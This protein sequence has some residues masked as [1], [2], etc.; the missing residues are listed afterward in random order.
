MTLGSLLTNLKGR[1]GLQNDST[2]DTLLRSWINDGQ[3]NITTRFLWPFLN[4]SETVTTSDGTDAYQLTADCLVYDVRDTTNVFTL[5]FLPDIE[6]DR[7]YVQQ[8]QTGVPRF[9]RLFGQTKVS[10]STA[11][12]PNL[13]LYPI[14]GGTYS[15]TVKS[16]K[17]LADMTDS[18]QI[19]EVP[20]AYHELMIHYAANIY[21]SSRGDNRAVEHFD[22]YEN[23]LADMVQQLGGMP[24]D[25]IDVVRSTDYM[26]EDTRVRFPYNFENY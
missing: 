1:C 23:K 13:Q 4:Q 26:A 6:F 20:E 17:R 9:Y 15:L 2:F 25:R 24:T 5:R 10:D 19:S 8:T 14:P 21:F 18:A 11:A 12:V 7:M 3:R 22:Q 16:Y